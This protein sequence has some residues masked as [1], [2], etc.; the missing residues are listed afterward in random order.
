MT[1]NSFELSEQLD[2]YESGNEMPL[3]WKEIPSIELNK[4][5]NKTITE[6]NILTYDFYQNNNPTEYILVGIEFVLEKESESD[7]DNFFSIYNGLDQNELRHTELQIE[8]QI[9]RIKIT[10]SKKLQGHTTK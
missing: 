8:N 7:Q 1:I 5:L 2:W 3:T 4:N 6:I 10:D 9:K